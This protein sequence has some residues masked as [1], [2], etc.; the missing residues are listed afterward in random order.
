MYDLII[1]KG[2][3]VTE[4]GISARDIAVLDQ[5][6]AKIADCI[7]LEEQGIKE[8]DAT[9]LHILPG[10]ID[11]HVHF[12]EPGPLDREGFASGSASLAASG[13]T[14]FFDHPVASDPPVI[15]AQAFLIKKGVGEE[16]SILDFALL[17]GL[18]PKNRD[19]LQA[20]KELG[21]IGFK[22]FMSNNSGMAEF[23]FLDDA[24]LVQGMATIA[25]LGGVLL[26]HAENEAIC[27]YLAAKN[28]A[29]GK[30]T[31]F[32]YEA[33]RP[34]LAEV[35]AVEKAAAFAEITHC[36]VH[37]L[38]VSSREVVQEVKR[39]KERGVDIT[40][41]TCP[42]YLA[43]SVEDFPKLAGAK[44]APPL[45][46]KEHIESLWEAIAAGEIDT[47][48]SDHSSMPLADGVW[49]GLSGGQST[50]SVLLEEG[51]FK[52]NIPLEKIVALT[53]CQ[54]AKRFGL[55]P[56]KGTIA[57]GAD[58]DLALVD[59]K[60]KYTLKK[61]ELLDRHSHSPYIGKTFRGTV[62][63]TIARGD[64]VWEQGRL[65]GKTGR[66]RIVTPESIK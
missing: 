47:I 40:V 6:I 35:A 33:S 49:G 66:G 34:V 21:A 65:S 28:L 24:G 48:G 32:D 42:H 10:L 30:T 31:F 43:L 29:G 9:G 3:V 8:I 7:P 27:S 54:P 17:G 38:H 2:L 22:G 15:D 61:E 56:R 13:V 51:Y 36:K 26:L 44:C 4:K 59:L 20:L 23:P 5:K 64:I 53:S 16:K 19:N 60:Q 46:N 11:E 55:Y 45:R 52:R 14:T 50:L 57:A 18:T 63:Y 62:K 58:A 12:D 25:E 37:I 41:E 39:A 1:R